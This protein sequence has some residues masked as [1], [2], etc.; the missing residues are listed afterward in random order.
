LGGVHQRR[1]NTELDRWVKTS[2]LPSSMVRASLRSC[3]RMPV[4][5]TLA[6]PGPTCP[7]SSRR[8]PSSM[9]RASLRSCLRMPVGPALALPRPT[10]PG[11]RRARGPGDGLIPLGDRE[12]LQL[13]RRHPPEERREVDH[14]PDV[15]DEGD[16]LPSV[17]M[18]DAH[19]HVLPDG[20][21]G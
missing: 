11:S 3:L 15:G 2:R 13:A 19:L 17:E 5:P 1:V 14:P 4:G 21:A 12:L 7:R 10:C 16:A 9:V 20:S 6:L 18:T 8:L